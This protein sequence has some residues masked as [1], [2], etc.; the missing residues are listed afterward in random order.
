MNKYII[1]LKTFNKY[2]Y[3][4]SLLIKKEI[5]KKY[6]GSMLGVLWSLVNPLLQMAVLTLVFSTLFNREI[7]NFPVYMLC[8]FLLFQFFSSTT[9]S[10]MRSM[11]TSESLIKKIYI[12]KY[13]IPLSIIVANF[14]F[15]LISMIDLIL[16][17]ILTGAHITV[18]IIYTPIYLV[19]FF[20]FCCG[21]S[22]ILTTVT[23]FF[24]DI[25]HIYG[26]LL[27][28][29]HFF[30]AVFYPPEIVPERYQF[31]LT[32]NPLYHY[33]KGFRDVLYVGISPNFTNILI[34]LGI[35]MLSLI[36]GILI[37]E[38]QQNKFVLY[39]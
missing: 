10:A 22:L 24:R 9:Q 23:V 14:I 25:E 7:S 28:A 32:F 30:S 19:L 11:I 21:I 16:V 5:K 37:F 31:I 13:I 38:K 4:L 35:A 27:M 6:R 20:V 34:C 29:I 15:F 17:M 2:S 8:G 1:Y 26:V 39:L 33:I 12:P 3:L 36:L 18:Y